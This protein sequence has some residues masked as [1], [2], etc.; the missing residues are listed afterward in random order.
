MLIVLLYQIV[1]FNPHSHAGSDYAEVEYNE[2]ADEIS[3]HTPTQGV[4]I[5]QNIAPQQTIDFN[6]HSHAGSDHGGELR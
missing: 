4:T 6:P 3:I 1:Y 5:Y 2:F